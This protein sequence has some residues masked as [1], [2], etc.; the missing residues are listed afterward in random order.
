[1]TRV[2]AAAFAILAL[3]A[4]FAVKPLTQQSPDATYHAAPARIH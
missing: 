4:L 2:Q 1:M 3:L